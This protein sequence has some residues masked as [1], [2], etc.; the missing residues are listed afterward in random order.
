MLKKIFAA[1]AFVGAALLLSST[2]LKAQTYLSNFTSFTAAGKAITVQAGPSALRLTFYTSDIVRVDYLPTLS[3]KIDSSLIVIRDT[4]TYVSL[5]ISEGDSS[6]TMTTAALRVVVAKYPVRVSFYEVTNKLL[7]FEPSG[8]GVGNASAS[9]LANFSFQSTDH[10]YGTGERGIRLDLRGLAFDSYN[11]QVGG[12]SS[13][14]PSTM[15]VNVPFVVS[16]DDYGVY[17]DNTYRGHFDIG[18]SLPNVLTYTSSGGELSYYF[19]H[20]MSMAEVLA[21]YTWLTG[22]APL[23]PAWAYGYIQSKFGY[24]NESDA[25]AMIQHMRTDSIP[26]DAIILDLY[27]FQNMGDLSWNTSLWPD[28]SLITSNFLSQGFKTI[29]IT[30]PYI[31]QSSANYSAADAGGYLAK[32]GSGQSYVLGGWWSCGCNAGLLDITNDSARAWW[33]SKY[34]SIFST[35][36]TGLW[37]DLGEPERD[38]SDMHFSLGSDTAIH[39][40]YDFLWAKTLFDGFNADYPSRRLF[41]L[42]RSG[43]AGIQRFNTVTWSGDVS[44]TFGGLAVQLPFLLNM[45][46]SGIAYQNSDIGGFDA[47]STSAELYTRWMEFGAFCPVMRAHGYDGDN[48][49][50]PWTFGAATENIVRELIRLRYALFPYNY[51]SAHQTYLAGMPLARPLALEF[52]DD[53]NVYNESSAYMWGDDFIVSPVV[54]SGQTSQSFYLPAGKWI[55]YWSDKVY[56]GGTTVTVPAPIDQVPLLVKSG[57]IIPMQPVPDYI[58]EYSADTLLL[59]IYPD[60]TVASSFELYED[61]GSSPLYQAGYFS[62]TEFE[63]TWSGTSNAEEFSISIGPAVGTYSG[64]SF[65]RVYLCEIHKVSYLPAEVLLGSVAMQ[66][67]PTYDSLE[68]ESSGFYYDPGAEILCTKFSGNTDRG[69]VVVLDSVEVTGVENSPGQ[70]TGYRLE[71]NFPNPFN[72]GTRIGFSIPSREKVSLVIFDSVGRRVSILVDAV[73]DAGR[74]E[75]AFDASRLSSGVYYVRMTAGSFQSSRAMMLL[76]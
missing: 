41:N 17:F 15:N 65:N 63:G 51:T 67:F 75:V 57:S 31:I 44:K 38:Y 70:P 56:S 39:N 40:I 58:G 50:E 37:T 68:A 43:Y 62:T 13:P 2:G 20:G 29:V 35:G 8:G 3:T 6:V 28:P 66:Q 7:L 14:P 16:T 5:Y 21:G 74:H 52:P 27:W 10:F 61:D 72:P 30:E 53:Q 55:D 19:I 22:R 47:G 59:A 46:M 54:Q 11:T 24:R 64:K 49:T 1:M 71:Q 4:S 32:N 48:G 42:T 23:L 33:W 76:K 9:R 26:C 73:L 18:K 69:Y 12:Y 45:G 36:V 34:E 25:E 60:P